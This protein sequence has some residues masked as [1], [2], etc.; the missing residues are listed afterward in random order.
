MNEEWVCLKHNTFG[1]SPLLG[2]AYCGKTKN[3]LFEKMVLPIVFLYRRIKNR[4][5]K[6]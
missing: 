4:V 6:T 3:N 2:C 5:R 1:D